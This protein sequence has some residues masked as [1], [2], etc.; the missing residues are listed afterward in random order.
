MAP[1]LASVLKSMAAVEIGR[2]LTLSLTL[3]ESTP[4]LGPIPI[5]ILPIGDSIGVVVAEKVTYSVSVFIHEQR[6]LL[7]PVFHSTAIAQLAL[8][9]LTLLCGHS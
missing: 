8:D 4:V 5:G 1:A 7:Q 9:G 3:L 2:S 6:A